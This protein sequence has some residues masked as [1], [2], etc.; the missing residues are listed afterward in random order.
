MERIEKNLEANTFVEP[1]VEPV[2]QHDAAQ[3]E[4]TKPPNSKDIPVIAIADGEVPVP[5]PRKRGRLMKNGAFANNNVDEE[6]T[7]AMPLKQMVALIDKKIT[8][9]R[10]LVSV[11]EDAMKG[12]YPMLVIAEDVKQQEAL[13]TL[14]VNKLRG[15]LKIVAL[16][17][18]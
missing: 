6:N 7:E 1:V 14:V 10:D 12:G 5:V 17:A 13:A 15:S 18:L 16:K 8:K 11:L 3:E 9:A 2:V 4:T